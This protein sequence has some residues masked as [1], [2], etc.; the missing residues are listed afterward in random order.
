MV[1]SIQSVKQLDFTPQGEGKTSPC[2][3][4]DVFIYFLL[5]DRFDNNQ[6]DLPAYD[7]ASAPEGRNPERGKV[8]CQ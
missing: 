4:Q 8:C 2:D 6:E 7:P 3:W 5:V 1:G